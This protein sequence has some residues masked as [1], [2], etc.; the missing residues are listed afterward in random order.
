MKLSKE[1]HVGLKVRSLKKRKRSGSKEV[2]VKKAKIGAMEE[3]MESAPLIGSA[4]TT[5]MLESF[6][7]ITKTSPEAKV[8]ASDPPIEVGIDDRLAA[9]SSNHP[10]K[11]GETILEEE[12]PLPMQ[13]MVGLPLEIEPAPGREEM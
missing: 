11:E 8:E 9:E 2:I 6:F 12:E 10:A 13:G 5:P 7:E 4:L 3:W 1:L